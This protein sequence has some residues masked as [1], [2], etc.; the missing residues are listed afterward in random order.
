M[1]RYFGI[2]LHKRQFTVCCLSED[3]KEEKIEE[4]EVSA[5]GYEKFKKRLRKEDEV[6]VEA[7]GNSGYFVEQI[8]GRA[9]KIAVINP[10]QFKVI[11]ESVKKTDKNDARV[12][13]EY[14]RHGLLPEVRQMSKE[15]RELKSLINTRDKLVKLRS[16]LKNKIHNILNDNGIVSQKEMLSSE[17][18]LEKVERLK[19]S[20]TVKFEMASLVL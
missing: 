18:S 19:L 5:R 14:L 4:Y 2:D 7:T 3:G 8:R 1:K 6:G 12:I 15:S 13:A 20:E 16:G 11:S 17:K 10:K 9:S